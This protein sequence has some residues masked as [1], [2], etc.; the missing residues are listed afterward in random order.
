[1]RNKKSN[2]RPFCSTQFVTFSFF[3]DGTIEV[4]TGGPADRSVADIAADVLAEGPM[5]LAKIV[6]AIREDTGR[7][8]SAQSLRTSLGRDSRRFVQTSG[9]RPRAW[10][11]R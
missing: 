1:M 9:K 3:G 5:P 7:D 8:M 10:S 2:A 11:L 6:A 4:A